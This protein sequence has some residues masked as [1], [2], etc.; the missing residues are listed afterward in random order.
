MSIY[1]T[2]WS[3]KFPEFGD[4][5]SGCNWIEVTAQGVPPHIGSP[6]PVV[7]YEDGDPYSEFLPP[8]VITNED[9][10]A[11]FMRAVVFVTENTAKGTSRSGQEYVN[12]LFTLTGAEYANVLF[13]ELHDR[14][15]GALRGNRPALTLEI[16]NPDGTL[17]L[18]FEDST[19]QDLD[20][21]A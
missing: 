8:A 6:T 16:I 17:K 4:Y 2:L 10:E 18:V 1:A 9:G 14:I 5:H 19:T 12:P 13:S 11:E 21:N 7:G 20:Q 15:C 3:L